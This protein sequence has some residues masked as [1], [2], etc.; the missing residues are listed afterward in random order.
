MHMNISPIKTSPVFKSNKE[1]W[2]HNKDVQRQL[3]RILPENNPYETTSKS[4]TQVT[5]DNLANQARAQIDITKRKN[6]S[7]QQ[8]NFDKFL[9]LIDERAG[10]NLEH[11]L[12]RKLLAQA[13]TDISATSKEGYD[14]A[15][16]AQEGK[17]VIKNTFSDILDE[18][19]EPD[20]ESQPAKKKR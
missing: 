16:L 4:Y 15:T 11:T 6:D 10:S 14:N 5:M 9:R 7:L 8:A 2:V 13:L 12:D 1:Q 20:L 3:K 18:F 19:V 17:E